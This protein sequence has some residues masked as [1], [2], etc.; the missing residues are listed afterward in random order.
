VPTSLIRPRYLIPRP[1]SSFKHSKIRSLHSAFCS[2]ATH[3]HVL[4]RPCT[5]MYLSDP[6]P[7]CTCQT[8]HHFTIKKQI[9]LRRASLS[10]LHFSCIFGVICCRANAD[11]LSSIV[12]VNYTRLDF[13]QCS[14]IDPNGVAVSTGVAD[15]LARHCQTSKIQYMRKIQMTDNLSVYRIPHSTIY[16][17]G[18]A[19]GDKPANSTD[20]D[21]WID[22][23]MTLFPARFLAS[24]EIASSHKL[25]VAY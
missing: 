6:A 13:A 4:V 11:L 1:T 9:G 7:P 19:C 21:L 22:S 15:I 3:H 8:P 25:G 20:A 10:A 2:E 17:D 16:A 12:N 23:Y 18:V 14:K 5:T 24:Q